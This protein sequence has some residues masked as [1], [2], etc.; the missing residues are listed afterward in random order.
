M[1]TEKVRREVGEVKA[2][3]RLSEHIM[4]ISDRIE[5]LKTSI[6]KLIPAEIK[7]L[8]I[9]DGE[10]WNLAASIATRTKEVTDG[11]N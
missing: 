6:D 3:H 11:I 10:C 9:L 1:T 8:N 5:Y 4:G 2:L 7:T